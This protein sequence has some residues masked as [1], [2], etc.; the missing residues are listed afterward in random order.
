MNKYYVNNIVDLVED[1]RKIPLVKW[2]NNMN[3]D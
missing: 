2:D 1:G 3:M